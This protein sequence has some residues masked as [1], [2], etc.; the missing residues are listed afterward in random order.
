[1]IARRRDGTASEPELHAAAGARRELAAAGDRDPGVELGRAVVHHHGLAVSQSPGR[2]PE[3]ADVALEPERLGERARR[4]HDMPAPDLGPLDSHERQGHP[5]ACPG[6]LRRPVV[7]LNASDPRLAPAGLDH[8]PVARADASRPERPRGDGADPAER[9][10]PVDREPHR[11]V[12]GPALGRPGGRD[13]GRRAGRRGPGRCAT[14]PRP[15]RRPRRGRPPAARR[16]R[17]AP[18]RPR[19]RRPGRASSA[20][21]TPSGIPSSC[22]IAACSRVCGMTPSSAATTS[23][24]RSIPVAPATIARMK[25]SCPGTSTTD[26]LRPDG[27]SSGAYPS[28]IEMPRAFSCGSR[29][30]SIPVSA[31]T[32][33]VLPWSMCPAVPRVR[34]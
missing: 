25:R 28:S 6:A 30:V 2:G 34:G 29:S 5:L 8:E 32:R 3:H 4:R 20:A 7:H 31:A 27:S 24:K 1:M 12:G 11:A 17:G 23:R 22:T 18:A 19:R 26:S 13:P 16:S 9:E 14:R 21:T 33:A 15:P 10:R